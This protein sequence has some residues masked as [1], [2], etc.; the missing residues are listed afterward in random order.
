M[1]IMNK[2]ENNNQ[3]PEVK[4]L[5]VKI[6]GVRKMKKQMKA[7]RKEAKK[8]IRLFKEVDELKKKLF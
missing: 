4:T 1:E 2:K 3:K 8:L 6:R 7:L 5:R